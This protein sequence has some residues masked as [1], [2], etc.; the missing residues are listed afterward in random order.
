M[1]DQEGQCCRSSENETFLPSCAL[2]DAVLSITNSY[3]LQ[4][5]PICLNCLLHLGPE[6]AWTLLQVKK[7]DSQEISAAVEILR[8]LLT[9]NQVMRLRETIRNNGRYW[10]V[11]LPEFGEYVCKLLVQKGFDWDEEVL[12]EIWDRLVAEAVEE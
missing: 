10:W 7:I 8:E 1:D 4:G 3:S 12:E 6:R 2:C 9:R 5:D 11:K